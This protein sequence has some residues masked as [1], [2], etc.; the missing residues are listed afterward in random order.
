MTEFWVSK[1]RYWCK[2]CKCWLA[3]N[4]SS[5]KIHE[6]GI[7]HKIPV[8]EF[9]KGTFSKGREDRSAQR[10]LQEE[11]REIEQV[12]TILASAT[13]THHLTPQA[14]LKSFETDLRKRGVHDYRYAA[15]KTARTRSR[16]SWILSQ[17]DAL[18]LV[19]RPEPVIGPPSCRNW[20]VKT[21][22]RAGCGS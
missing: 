18:C 6:N 11:L 10:E 17:H 12:R 20:A 14:A 22:G 8:S 2:H 15:H 9:L 19:R 16:A 7:G 4:V 3:D 13:S 5:R 1:Q 21:R